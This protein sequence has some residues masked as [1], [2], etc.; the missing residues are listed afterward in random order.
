MV[1]T[2]L[3]HQLRLDDAAQRLA[4]EMKLAAERIQELEQ[5]NRASNRSSARG[6]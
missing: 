2:G 6:K 4:V 1:K 3:N 5:R